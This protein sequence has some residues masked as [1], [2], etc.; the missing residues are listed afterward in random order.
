MLF[1][2]PSRR[3]ARA[4]VRFSLRYVFGRE[5]RRLVKGLRLFYRVRLEMVLQSE[6][7]GRI[8][9]RTDIKLW[10]D[11]EEAFPRLE[12][13][14]RKARH[15]VVIQMF[16]WRDDHTGRRMAAVLTEIAD[17]GVRVDITKEAI[18]DL[19]EARTDFYGSRT[20]GHPVWERFWNHPRITVTYEKHNDH[21]KAYVIDGDVL[22]LTGMNIGDEYRYHWHDYM[23][24]LRGS[25][26]VREYLTKEPFPHA[27]AP[28]RLVMNSDAR[29][30]IRP[31]VMGLLAGARQSIIAEQCYLS[32]AA[33]VDALVAR[34]HEGIRIVV[35]VPKRPGL[36]YN[37]N[38]QSLARL[39]AEGDRR[40]M[41]VLL[42]PGIVHG[43][44]LLVDRDTAFIGSANL[45][46][47]SL[48]EMGEVNVIIERGWGKVLRKL[49]DTLRDDALRS[50]PLADVPYLW[51]TTK[52]LAWMGL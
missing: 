26:F 27:E 17:R 5:G 14:L 22:V 42:Y 50:R 51:W 46:R 39:V 18:G 1:P 21:T 29:K 12:R 10:V 2:L 47:S 31:A 11:G 20:S 7:V 41:Q 16:I 24:E 35:I 30:D 37:A 4:L 13:L 23:V 36:H 33:V 28:V 49:R 45:M 6:H 19:F 8:A 32:D 34:S 44:I 25:R 52:V 3:L 43:K 38:L 40:S 15:S 48:D 9:T